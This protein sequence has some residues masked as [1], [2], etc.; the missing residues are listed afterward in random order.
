MELIEKHNCV[1]AP[2][3]TRAVTAIRA[4]YRDYLL[5]RHLL[6]TGALVGPVELKFAVIP[7]KLATFGM[8]VI[9]KCRLP[10]ATSIVLIV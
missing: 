5:V 7:G 9:D 10:R 8:T 2:A 6:N 4:P 3:L 1:L